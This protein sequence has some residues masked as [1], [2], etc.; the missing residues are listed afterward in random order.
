MEFK[1][2]KAAV[3]AHAEALGLQD[4]ELYYQSGSD[5]TVSAF[6]HEINEFSSSTDGGV[7]FRCLVNGKMGYASTQELSEAS[8]VRIVE[9]ARDNAA[10]LE[11]EEAEFLCSGGKTYAEPQNP[12]YPLPSA[13]KLIASVLDLQDRM[14]RENPA[15]IDGTAAQ[16]TAQTTDIAICNSK[17][18]DLSYHASLCALIAGPTVT[19][20]KE[21][22]ND[23]SVKLGKPDTIDAGEL[24]KKAVTKT[25]EKLGGEVPATGSCPVVFSTGAMTSLLQTFC[26]IFS[27]ENAQKGLSR[28]AGQEGSVI[29]APCVTLVDDPFCKDSPLP[30]HF[31]A[32][33]CPT[34][35]KNVIEGGVLSTLLYNMKTAAVAGRET[36]GNAYKAGYAAPVGI[37]PFAMY[38]QG[39]DL[40]EEALFEKAGNGVYITS[41]GGLHA[42][43]NAITGD[44]SL[45]SSGFLIENGKKTTHVKS[46]TVAGNFYDLLK[47]ITA[48]ADNMELPMPF[49]MTC[50]G[51]PSVLVEGL[52]IAGK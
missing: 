14:Y 38:L 6:Q 41:L 47:N 20:G 9:H 52:S 2:F 40:S 32:E 42:G 5:L 4:Y 35:R 12:S 34:C 36:T 23:Y 51:A 29:A 50:F 31:D 10:C 30:I 7:C 21:M 17:G 22:E 45:Q 18:L 48:L 27:S 1:N 26:G 8:A 28:L 25:L 3:Q 43:A 24:A 13:E 46:F 44:F 37:Q 33:G 16:G 49:G 15:V 39:G 11:A 19:D